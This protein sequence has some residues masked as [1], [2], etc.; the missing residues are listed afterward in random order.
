MLVESQLAL[1]LAEA[2]VYAQQLLCCT[3]QAFRTSGLSLDVG[4]A[5]LWHLEQY[6]LDNGQTLRKELRYPE[7][8]AGEFW[9]PALSDAPRLSL[10]TF[11]ETNL[12]YHG[13]GQQFYAG[14]EAS[15]G[16]CYQ[17]C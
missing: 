6:A 12:L 13:K 8:L 2:E 14:K 9:S 17:E 5:E 1:P 4:D 15:H 3:P 11:R 10:A 7:Q 16:I